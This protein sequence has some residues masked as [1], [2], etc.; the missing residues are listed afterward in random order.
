V[1]FPHVAARGIRDA[2]NRLTSTHGPLAAV[3][4]AASGGDTLF[5]EHAAE[6][7]L[8]LRVLL[9]FSR[10]R[11]EQDFQPEEWQRVAAVLNRVM[12]IEELP[13]IGSAKEA[14]YETGALTVE[15]ADVM[16]F[17]WDGQGPRG[18]GGTADIVE[19]ARALE[20]PLI[21]VDPATGNLTEERVER[22]PRAEG[23]ETPVD[24]Y[25]KA[26]EERFAGMNAAATRHAPRV[27]RLVFYVIL[28]HLFASVVGLSALILLAGRPNLAAEL[29]HSISTLALCIEMAVLTGALALSFLHRRSH[30]E[31]IRNRLGAELCR[32]CL[33]T[34]EMHHQPG[35]FPKTPI[36]GFERL[37][38]SLR[39][40][41]LLDRSQRPEM[42]AAKSDYLSRRVDDQIAYYSH[43]GQ[44]AEVKFGLWRKV[45]G[46][47]T[48]LAIGCTIGALWLSHAADEASARQQAYYGV[49]KLL[50]LLLPLINAAALSLVI[51]QEYS[52]RFVRYSQMSENLKRA[53]NQIQ[54]VKTWPTLFRIIMDTEEKLLAEVVEW[55]SYVRFVGEAH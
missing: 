37:G 24:D 35:I 42:E 2:L 10:T 47:A 15:Y 17:L 27:R 11:F 20:K 26:T 54:A 53:R 45:A 6:R 16:V 28:L 12:I 21:I 34:W 4:S 44:A 8:P 22:L 30:V 18:L 7:G 3:S 40:A 25:R 33:A 5:L 55:H 32:S 51:A 9:P 1:E 52:R 49:L 41:W 19:Y 48:V 23:V 29:R 14:F 36:E 46:L 39:I 13:T 38:R 31:W 43:H 50:G